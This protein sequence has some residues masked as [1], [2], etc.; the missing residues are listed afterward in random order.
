M[1]GG[2]ILLSGLRGI[3]KKFVTAPA[4]NDMGS[5]YCSRIRPDRNLV[6]TKFGRR[7]MVSVGITA[8]RARNNLW[9]SFFS[10]NL[11]I[12]YTPRD[13]LSRKYVAKNLSFRKYE[14]HV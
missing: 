14:V 12:Y 7:L 4:H 5:K 8:Y 10:A 2:L 9:P 1:P 13:C 6:L 11:D 3:N